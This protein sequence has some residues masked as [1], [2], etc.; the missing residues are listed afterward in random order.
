MGV[1]FLKVECW[2]ETLSNP[3]A[4]TL[5]AT[6][7]VSKDVLW[8]DLLDYD[9][10]EAEEDFLQQ[11]IAL[12]MIP[13]MQYDS[14]EA[15]SAPGNDLLILTGTGLWD[16]LQKGLMFCLTSNNKQI[17]ALATKLIARVHSELSKAGCYGCIGQL[18]CS[19]AHAA[20]QA[21]SMRQCVAVW[22]HCMPVVR[23][24]AH[25]LPQTCMYYTE[26]VLGNIAE[27]ICSLLRI[28]IESSHASLQKSL[29]SN[30]D[31]ECSMRWWHSWLARAKIA[32]V[33]PD[34]LTGSKL[35]HQ[36]LGTVLLAAR[37]QLATS[38][39]TLLLGVHVVTGALSL[40]HVRK[41]FP[42]DM[43]AKQV[44]LEGA[45]Q[46]VI[47]V[48]S[49]LPPLPNTTTPPPLATSNGQADLEPAIQTRLP[50]VPSEVR[51]AALQALQSLALQHS[52]K[53]H[54]IFS[55]ANVR[56]LLQPS[57]TV[58][59]Q[60][61][62]APQAVKGS[63]ASGGGKN[64]VA[65]RQT[66][67]TVGK[68][69][70]ITDVDVDRMAVEMH[71]QLCEIVR[72]GSASVACSELLAASKAIKTVGCSQWPWQHTQLRIC[73]Q[74]PILVKTA[75]KQCDSLNAA[76]VAASLLLC[77]PSAVSGHPA[78]TSD[79]APSAVVR[80][81]LGPILRAVQALVQT[82][83]GYEAVDAAGVPNM[84]IHHLNHASAS[85]MAADAND[86]D[87][88][89]TACILS[90]CSQ[91]L[92]SLRLS[93]SPAALQ[94]CA[95]RLA[96]Q[97]QHEDETSWLYQASSLALT[98]AGQKALLH[99]GLPQQLLHLLY[100]L[101]MQ[102]TDHD[103]DAM[104]EQQHAKLL[105]ACEV[106]MSWDGLAEHL[107][108]ANV[109]QQIQLAYHSILQD[110][111]QAGL[112]ASPCP[113]SSSADCPILSTL[114]GAEAAL[115][116][117]TAACIPLRCRWVLNSHLNLRN[118]LQQHLDTQE[119]E[120]GVAIIDMTSALRQQLLNMLQT[121]QGLTSRASLATQAASPAQ[122]QP[123]VPQSFGTASLHGRP[124]LSLSEL[125]VLDPGMKDPQAW[126]LTVQKALLVSIE[127]GQLQWKALPLIL[128]RAVMVA[129]KAS[130]QEGLSP[131]TQ[132]LQAYCHQE[133]QPRMSNSA[134]GSKL[135]AQCPPT[136]ACQPELEAFVTQAK[137][138]MPSL[139]GRLT[140]LQLQ[141]FLCS[142][143]GPHQSA[144]PSSSSSAS[145]I[146][147]AIC[148]WW[149]TLPALFGSS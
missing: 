137:Q 66:R 18:V 131:A 141:D 15:L 20:E 28:C 109:G 121:K 114:E 132:S 37:G 8:E 22:E 10:D 27:A 134:A 94:C 67:P 73:G 130:S 106:V 90:M 36:A 65:E 118:R 133:D 116:L 24:V 61:H 33:L 95:G 31:N 87:M 53:G 21:P 59:A 103:T 81:A 127:Q 99:A 50:A 32:K 51:V 30:N 111:C 35:L 80:S 98:E 104:R 47:T 129:M 69:P 38:A 29:T 43:S 6:Q 40:S 136:S 9:E 55:P 123:H 25:Q 108:P 92:L 112:Q 84:L 143:R 100:R 12:L 107:L 105:H 96:A 86:C 48:F 145:S 72:A 2:P 14:L 140:A 23:A 34:C 115:R 76:D 149:T 138:Q 7:Q 88:S 120:A 52:S 57:L 97:A 122:P 17:I 74:K 45:L 148:R 83:A 70:G 135:A 78:D 102:S 75:M 5:K 79:E 91:P 19:F 119:K 128:Q 110:L 126:L 125:S 144:M 142:M 62:K 71:K 58:L 49:S 4:C 146:Q 56:Q 13:N 63:L 16:P 54:Q 82:S 60:Q 139:A 41:L 42:I 44:S 89:I 11:Y 1:D 64:G 93:Q 39:D 124:G 68:L 85:K 147:E 113:L 26:E 3:T 117:L 77:L 101:P 46:A